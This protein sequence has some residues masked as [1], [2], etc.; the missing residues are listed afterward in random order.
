MK[1]ICKQNLS[2]LALTILALTLTSCGP[3]TQV[4]SVYPTTVPWATVSPAQTAKNEAVLAIAKPL[5]QKANKTYLIPGWIHFEIRTKVTAP[6]P[7][8]S[9]AP[10]EWRDETWALLDETGDATQTISIH[11]TG[12]VETSYTTIFQDGHWS[13]LSRG[14]AS[15]YLGKTYPIRLDFGF[16]EGAEYYINAAELGYEGA[17]TLGDE[18]VAIFTMTDIKLIGAQSERTSRLA[19]ADFTKY[20][21]ST[22]DGLLVKVEA[23]KNSPTGPLL[24]NQQTITL[25]ENVRRPPA[26][27][28]KNLNYIPV[29]QIPEFYPNPSTSSIP[30]VTFIPLP[31]PTL[32]ADDFDPAAA[33]AQIPVGQGE[34]S[35][36]AIS[37]YLI[38]QHNPYLSDEEKI[39]YLIEAYFTTHYEGQKLVEVQD[40]SALIEDNTLAW[41][42]KEK[43]VRY[44]E[45][46]ITF[47]FD[48]PYQSYK[49][50]PDYQTIEINGNEATVRLL[51]SDQVIYKPYAPNV[52]GM[53]GEL[54]TFIL[55]KKDGVWVIYTETYENEQTHALETRSKE[56]VLRQVYENYKIGH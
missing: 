46:Y 38:A 24:V 55:H 15:D 41:V 26:E 29:I 11:D 36:L 44:I 7:E 2:L 35:R 40:F 19:V 37:N 1:S 51:L 39:K 47:L 18:R 14:D 16:L 54:H 5:I 48:T 50:T 45:L 3:V 17:D 32:G 21:F 42:Q 56:Q 8:G 23:Y 6:L 12:N 20:Y 34:V 52:S 49:F 13:N 33:L 53:S 9:S 30:T 31:V 4:P 27:V 28:L 25:V 10:L 43:D 22:A